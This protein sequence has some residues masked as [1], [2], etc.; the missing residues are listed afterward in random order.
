MHRRD[1]LFRNAM[2]INYFGDLVL[3]AGWV[4]LT[5]RWVLLVVPGLMLLGFMFFNMPALDR[6]LAE[7]Y[8]EAFRA[9]V[10]RTKK[11]IPFLY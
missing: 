7:R 3:F 11:L 5:R 8:G 2:H 6:Y 9:D 10:A 4:L 1:G